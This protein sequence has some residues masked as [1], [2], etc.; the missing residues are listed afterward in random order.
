M[1]PALIFTRNDWSDKPIRAGTGDDAGHVGI[2]L[3]PSV[4][5]TTLLHGVKR[6][7]SETWL[8]KRRH[9]QTIPVPAASAA[10]ADRASA[11]LEQAVRENWRYD[12]LEI[13]GFLLMRDL[14]DPNRPVCS[15]LARTWFELQT[16]HQLDTRRGRTSP[17]LIR[18]AAGAYAAGLSTKLVQSQN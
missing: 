5:D 16:G 11:Y 8:A 6:W 14:G 3:G 2:L 18:V 17:R 9:V 10:H 1:T 4:V 12:W 15:S 7:D 13:L